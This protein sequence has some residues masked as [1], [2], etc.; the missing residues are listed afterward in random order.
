[1]PPCYPFA[2]PDGTTFVATDINF[3]GAGIRLGL[4]GERRLLRCSGLSVYSKGHI[5]ALA[6]QFNCDYLQFNQF[7]GVEAVVGWSDDRVITISELEVG[8]GWTNCRG[9]VKVSL[10]YYFAIWDNVVTTPEWIN[11]AQNVSFIDV[12]NDDDDNLA[13]DGL[14]AARRAAVLVRRSESAHP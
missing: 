2:P 9:N 11:A 5:N 12:N 14:V 1:M 6:G 3:D 8:L 7:N 13:F 4:E 10:G